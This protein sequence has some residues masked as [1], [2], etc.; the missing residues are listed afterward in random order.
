M[1]NTKSLTIGQV[2]ATVSIDTDAGPLT[3]HVKTKPANTIDEA[4]NLV[5]A[6]LRA[7][8]ERALG[9]SFADRSGEIVALEKRLLEVQA[10][11][12]EANKPK[13]KPAAKYNPPKLS[14]TSKTK[15]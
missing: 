13:P 14:Q 2:T 8:A 4:A 3:F 7:I 12:D 1:A 6:K 5:A 15:N 11:L 10:K 9:A